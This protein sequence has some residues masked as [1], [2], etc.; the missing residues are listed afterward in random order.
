MRIVHR[1]A[2][3]MVVGVLTTAVQYLVFIVLID[4]TRTPIL[5]ASTVGYLAGTINSYLLNRTWTFQQRRP[6]S[7]PEL[8]R[9]CIVNAAS[10]LVNLAV[11]QWLVSTLGASPA[12]AQAI[13]IAASL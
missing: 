13:A 6:P 9:F 7:I 2:L 3:Y 12:L 8:L 10:L 11:L 4:W 1:L 5:G